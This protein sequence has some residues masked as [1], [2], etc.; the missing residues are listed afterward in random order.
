MTSPDRA[1]TMPAMVGMVAAL[2]GLMFSAQLERFAKSQA[3][4]AADQLALAHE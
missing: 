1:A 4:R 3:R 2:S